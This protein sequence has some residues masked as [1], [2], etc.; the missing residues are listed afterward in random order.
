[1]AADDALLDAASVVVDRVGLARL[2]AE[3]VALEAGI[4]RVTL[5]RRG[6]T[7]PRLIAGLVNRAAQEFRDRTWPAMTG[8]GTASERL[9]GVLTAVCES[10]EQHLGVLAGVFDGPS[11]LFHLE[12]A[13][14]V[15]TRLEFVD[16]IRRLLTDGQSDGS[17]RR[18]DPEPVAEVLFNQ[19][20][21]TYVHLRRSHGWSA[22]RA[23]EHLVAV[24][25]AGVTS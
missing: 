3:A 4:N 10:A 22:R 18:L 2:T 5:Y 13:E 14:E 23:R 1:M 17:I 15:V 12:G 6:A 21:W 9:E 19:V 20:G 11:A 16:P 8:P 25:V 24:A 7:P